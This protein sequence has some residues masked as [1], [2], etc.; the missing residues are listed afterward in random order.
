MSTIPDSST[1][2]NQNRKYHNSIQFGHSLVDH[3]QVLKAE[4]DLVLQSPRHFLNIDNSLQAT[5]SKLRTKVAFF[6][7]QLDDVQ[8]LVDLHCRYER[9]TQ[10]STEKTL[11]HSCRD[12]VVEKTEDAG[13][14]VFDLFGRE[15]V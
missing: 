11:S 13:H 10:P 14:L 9:L 7:K 4:S 6:H 12:G 2:T 8:S 3:V 15:D 1:I 5:V